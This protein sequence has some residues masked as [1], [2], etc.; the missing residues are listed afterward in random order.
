MLPSITHFFCSLPL[1]T[2]E[3]PSIR[4]QTAG[5]F[6]IRHPIIGEATQSVGRAIPGYSHRR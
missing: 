3:R 2:R 4:L 5:Q 6:T 1:Y